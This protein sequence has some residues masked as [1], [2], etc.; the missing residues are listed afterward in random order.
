[1][2]IEVEGKFQHETLQCLLGVEDSYT[3]AGSART[4]L[5]FLNFSW[6]PTRDGQ[7]ILTGSSAKIVGEGYSDAT[8]ASE[9]ASFVGKPGQQHTLDIDFLHD[10]SKL[11]VANPRTP[12]RRGWN[13]LPATAQPLE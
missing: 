8:V 9:V 3:P 11:S 10:G 13:H 7:T 6:K 2:E 5:Q 1:M 4:S 12:H